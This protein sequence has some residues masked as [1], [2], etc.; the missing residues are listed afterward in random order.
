MRYY[1][2][3]ILVGLSI[4][5]FG[6]ETSLRLRQLSP[7][8]GF[9][10][11]AIF[12]IE[13]DHQGFIW[14]GTKNGLFK[15]DSQNIIKFNNV[16]NDPFSLIDNRI[17]L[18]KR[19]NDNK[20][21]IATE[22]GLC[23]YDHNNNQFI[24]YPIYNSF[25]Q[26][27]DENI[28]SMIF[29]ESRNLW[30]ISN[31]GLGIV[32]IEN[33]LFSSIDIG[34]EIINPNGLYFD[35]SNRIWLTTNDGY[36]FLK[37]DKYS[38][39]KLFSHTRN[40]TIH[41]LAV[42]KEN[43]WLGY[44]WQGVDCIGMDGQLLHHYD[45][46]NEEPFF[47][48]NNRVRSICIDGSDRI[49]IGT[50]RGI[51]LINADGSRNII[52][53]DKNAEL[54]VNS[55]H[56]IFEDKNEGIWIGCW[57]GGLSYYNKY[58][59]VFHHY[60][61]DLSGNSISDNV[62]SGFAE[63]AKGNIWVTTENNGINYFNR[64]TGNFNSITF[65]F[66]GNNV[67]NFKSVLVDK[68]E[69]VWAGTFRY[70]LWYKKNGNKQ[71]QRLNIPEL[72]GQHVYSINKNGNFLWI[73]AYENGLFKLDLQNNNI[74]HFFHNPIDSRTIS[75]NGI[76]HVYTDSKENVWV[77]THFGLNLKKNG[78]DYFIRFFK[79]KNNPY[80]L[81]ANEVFYCFEDSKGNIW[82]CTGGGGL[83]KS[84]S[85]DFKFK[86]YTTND[87]L[88]GNYVFG[89]SEDI[90]GN[91]WISTNQGLSFLNTKT[92]KFRNFRAIDGIQSNQFNPGAVFKTSSGEM[93]FG[94]PNGFTLFDPSKIKLNPIKPNANI[95]GFKIQNSD[96]NI[97][98]YVVNKRN[99]TNRKIVLDN[100]QNA[101]SFSFAADN[102]LLP[103][104]NKF[105][106][107]LKNFNENWIDTEIPIAIYTNIPA[108]SYTFELM[109]ANNDGIWNDTPYRLDI[110]IKKP[111]AL[112]N[113]AL[114]VYLS[115]TLGLFVISRKMILERQR[116]RNEIVFEKIQR[117]NEEELHQMK[118]KFFTNI[119]HE[120]RTPLS[121]ILMPLER[122]INKKGFNGKERNELIIVRNN[123]SRL[124]RLIN[125][126]MD[127]RKIDNKRTNLKLKRVNMINFCK[128]IY[129]CFNIYAEQ[130]SIAYT[131]EAEED[132]IYAEID[133]EMIDKIVYNLLSNAFKFTGN[134]GQI[135]LSLRKC[136][137]NSVVYN[138]SYFYKTGE[139]NAEN[140]IEITVED[141]GIGIT[142]E[143]LPMIFERFYQAD[144]KQYYGTGLGLA[145][146]KEYVMLHHGEISVFSE[147]NKG[148]RFKVRIPLMQLNSNTG[149]T[150]QTEHENVEHVELKEFSLEENSNTNLENEN[151]IKLTEPEKELILLVEDNAELSSFIN[152]LLEDKYKVIMAVDGN[153]GLRDARR[154]M[155]DLIISDIMMPEMDGHE[156]SR[157]LKKDI[158]I[159][160]IPIIFLT[161]LNSEENQIEGLKTGVDDY[162]TKPFNENILLLKIS[163]L[164][165]SRKNLREKYSS[166]NNKWNNQMIG[167]SNEKLFVG[168][169]KQI[170]LDNLDNGSLS[171]EDVAMK[172][173]ISRSQLQRKLKYLTNYN[174][175]EF[176][177]LTRL[178]KAVE[179]LKNGH[180]EIDQVGYA[181]GFNS[182][183][184]FSKCFK[185]KYGVTPSEFIS[186]FN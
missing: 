39:F 63:D 186:K 150:E 157:E 115:I 97:S 26:Q 105:R 102:Y 131:F 119:S 12:S 151:S 74:K 4:L 70:G 8:G 72:D 68:N 28:T 141:T 130:K 101:F 36:L 156:F 164:L 15:H 184:Y 49:W 62:I 43:I 52:Q 30:I 162:L 142:K 138:S 67:F 93:L 23:Y 100:K 59:N 122:I 181:V 112:S 154:Y 109:A 135:L 83:S 38:K 158:Q 29:D 16:L 126:L 176:I 108:G 106:Y 163:N 148:S 82:V 179:L 41:T 73:A 34:K 33:H 91:M 139:L 103:E 22:G 79:E 40:A 56:K 111:L 173:G 45:H 137:S 27:V 168:K 132:P 31:F 69:T 25:K 55:V 165:E 37:Q 65:N 24:K 167:L 113:L 48:P 110:D 177:R 35:D 95:S 159:S 128:E 88:A 58:D 153:Q 104:K 9:S 92:D 11:S 183:S 147:I 136:H 155:P 81:N 19:G 54:P 149:Q 86:T 17:N 175:T 71:F 77:S 5:N 57:S 20:L 60:K 3:L 161:A 116:L 140:Y 107:R 64:R 44:D 51:L 47:L 78:S 53:Q 46:S 98:D 185:I 171:V 129:E 42:G 182:Q 152:S 178:E 145:L 1:L 13:Q 85:E 134:N 133:T 96:A 61:N 180:K 76:R 75:N 143:K 125:Q 14:F 32:D 21:W 84:I 90:N 170:I 166:N 146:S 89:I 80:S 94:G 18:I 160:H 118:L 124:L 6:Q 169:V 7:D 121:L 123:A 114:L 174:P 10:F 120:F 87:G 99:S 127:L 172:I 2:T 117:K 66:E 50:F 144:E